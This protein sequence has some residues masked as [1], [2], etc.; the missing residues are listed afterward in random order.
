MNFDISR[1]LVFLIPLALIQFGLTIAAVVH[2][3]RH[4]TYAHGNRAIWLLVSILINTIGPIL[5][6]VFGRDDAREDEGE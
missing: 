2:I 5:Y 3:L 1:F 4:K 6:F